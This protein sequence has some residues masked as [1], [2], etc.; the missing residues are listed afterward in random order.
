MVQDAPDE[1]EPMTLQAPDAQGASIAD[2]IVGAGSQFLS[3]LQKDVD[4]AKINLDL[5]DKATIEAARALARKEGLLSESERKNETL[6]AE[7]GA[8]AS[9]S[10]TDSLQEA[11][12]KFIA[13]VQKDVEQAK[14]RMNLADEKSLAAERLFEEA[15][16]QLSLARTKAARQAAEAANQTSVFDD[17]FDPG[18]TFQLVVKQASSALETV[19][20]PLRELDVQNYGA[21]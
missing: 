4:A 14:I 19:R 16:S 12:A 13:E 15:Q 7:S 8:K 11:S 20:D 2:A 6:R 1:R 18:L 17:L 21:Q 10:L 5:A 3:E 9:P